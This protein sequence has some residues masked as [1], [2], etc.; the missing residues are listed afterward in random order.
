MRARIVELLALLSMLLIIIA[1]PA[2][3]IS[4][5]GAIQPQNDGTYLVR[6][7]FPKPYLR[8]VVVET[9]TTIL[10]EYPTNSLNFTIGHEQLD[11]YRDGVMIRA[12]IDLYEV[13]FSMPDPK[14]SIEDNKMITYY[15]YGLIVVEFGVV[16]LSLPFRKK[17]DARRSE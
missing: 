4:L 12:D 6:I 7:I 13:T 11:L 1:I 15:S 5:T 14:N 9:N 10:S 2:H 3:A 8:F 17:N 16:A